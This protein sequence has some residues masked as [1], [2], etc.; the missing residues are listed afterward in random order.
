MTICERRTGGKILC[1]RLSGLG[2]VVHALNSLSLLRLGRPDAHITWLVEDRFSGL[3]RRHPHIDELITVPRKVWGAMLKNPFRWYTL[4]PELKELGGFL[5][6]QGFDISLDFQS[7]LKSAWLVAAAGAAV[8]VGFGGGVSREFNRLVQNDLVE[9]PGGGVHRIE[10]DLALLA[11]LGIAT[12]Y[13][14]PVLPACEAEAESVGA[15][16]EERLGGGP[17]VVIHPGTS[18]FAAFKRWMP[19]RYA[20]VADRLVAERGADVVVTC[21]PDDAALAER[22]VALMNRKGILAQPTEGVRQL[23]CL[24]RRADLF[25]GSDTGPMHIASALRVPVV[26][27]FGPKD[28]VQTGPYCSRSIVV[29]GRAPCRPCTRRR[30]S[31]VRCMTSIT[32]EKVL[33]A[34]L[35][36]LGGGGERRATEGPVRA[37]FTYRFTLGKWRGRMATA[38]SIPELY[39]RLCDPD[40]M[41]E[42]VEARPI[43]RTRERLVVS[44]AAGVGGTTQP[45]VAA[46]HHPAVR[47][48]DVVLDLVLKSRARNSW[49]C[50]AGLELRRAP[51]PFHVCHMTKGWGWRKEQLLVTEGRL[52]ACTLREW[53]VAGDGP[54]W[55][56]GS[57][58]ERRG[59]IRKLAR[60][61]RSF[62]AAGYWHTDLRDANVL[63]RP[64]ANVA[65]SELRISGLGRARRV[66]CLPAMLREMLYGLDLARFALS[67]RSPPSMLDG[68]RFLRAYCEDMKEPLHRGVLRHVVGACLRRHLK[69]QG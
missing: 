54:N 63:I 8:R 31:H 46:R 43:A 64:S 28:P 13:A 3:L 21:G 68:V 27:L 15:T 67:F 62:H 29:N 2:D 10:R 37:P 4:G 38:Y 39:K 69:R 6:E 60:A 51:V 25:I 16:L 58:Q 12:R 55:R 52:G 20:R 18:K 48:P 56:G 65:D 53:L 49:D 17:L 33:Q 32:V 24:L 59:L 36:V 9:V 22:V 30:C 1:I 44:L 66:R 57:G 41:V 47:F 7:S 61:I 50:A 11:P 40:E 5:R 34:A 35:D 23:V 19:H 14:G 42:G 45:L 26:A